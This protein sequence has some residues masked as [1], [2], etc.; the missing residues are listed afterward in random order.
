MQR[1]IAG[2]DSAGMVKPCVSRSVRRRHESPPLKH[3]YP[4]Q[5]SLM[6]KGWGG[7]GAWWRRGP[8]SNRPTRICNPV[9]NRFATAP[10]SDKKGK[11]GLPLLEY[12][13]GKRVSNS[14]PQPWQG[15]ALPTELF[16]HRSESI[17]H[18]RCSSQAPRIILSPDQCLTAAPSVSPEATTGATTGSSSLRASGWR[19]RA[20]C[21]T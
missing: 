21:K 20:T 7:V 9:H 19:S 17:T 13:S 16:P 3:P 5:L 15:C 11:P 18:F 14:R 6:K 1:V 2:V 10:Y 4:L 12:W 8:E